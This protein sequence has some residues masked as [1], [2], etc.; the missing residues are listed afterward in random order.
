VAPL[1]LYILLLTLAPILDTFRLSLSGSDGTAFPSATNYTRIFESEV[2]RTA[3]KNT[4]IVA[5]L[6]LLLEL[7]IGL[8]TAL[9]LNAKFRGRSLV[10]TIILIPLGVPTIVSGA[11]MLLLFSRS[12]YLN[13]LLAGV[14][15]L[16]N[17]LP[18]PDWTFV[19][20]SWTV[21]GGWRTL[22]TVA[23]ADMWKVLPVV[24]L[25]FLAGLQSISEDVYEAASV[26]GASKWQTFRKI[27]L[28]MLVP[29]ITMA[30]IL[31]AIDAFR[32]YELALV[33]AGRVEPVLGTYIGQRYLPPVND[34][35]TAASSSIVLFLMILAF[36]VVYLKFVAL[37]DGP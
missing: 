1:I 23:I 21:A 28:P 26:D 24:V 34:V 11:V 20:L 33:L 6:S 16:F 31:R 4:L 22:F 5:L 29:F 36:I 37:K 25:I 8:A 14:A 7:V 19:P 10:R 9:A 13:S 12:G 32:I 3:F 17:K 18:L 27:T 30:V 15:D 2:F 35:F